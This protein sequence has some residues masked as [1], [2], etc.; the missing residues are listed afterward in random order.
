M[1]SVTEN[2]GKDL[3]HCAVS[4]YLSKKYM[5]IYCETFVLTRDTA[6]KILDVVDNALK[7]HYFSNFGLS[8]LGWC[9]N[10]MLDQKFINY[11]MENSSVR[12]TQIIE[13]YCFNYSPVR[14]NKNKSLEDLK[15]CC[16]CLHGHI[17]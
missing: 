14:Y 5:T 3:E 15:I 4:N 9:S 2:L 13:F 6:N 12:K 8:K 17:F 11:L 7:E 1:T 10:Y 16:D